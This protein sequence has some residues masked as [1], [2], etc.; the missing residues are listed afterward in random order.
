MFFF[1]QVNESL[2]L[3]N[4]TDITL[5]E[6]FPTE[7]MLHLTPHSESKIHRPL[8]NITQ[9]LSSL[10]ICLN[11]YENRIGVKV[12]S[13]TI[14]NDL[15][16]NSNAKRSRCDSNSEK[17]SPESKKSRTDLPTDLPTEVP[18]MTPPSSCQA[19]VGCG[20]DAS[21]SDEVN[22]ELQ[23]FLEDSIRTITASAKIVAPPVKK[24]KLKKQSRSIDVNSVRPLISEEVVNKIRKGWTI[25]NAAD[26]TIG[27]LYCVFGQDSKLIF[28]YNWID[29]PPPAAAPLPP[30]NTICDTPP[31]TSSSSSASSSSSSI[32]SNKLKHLLMIANLQEQQRTNRLKKTNCFCGH[33]CD[34]TNIFNNKTYIAT[35]VFDNDQANG[36]L[37]MVQNGNAVFR[38]PMLPFRRPTFGV[39]GL[40][41]MSNPRLR[42]R[43]V[44]VQRILPLHP[45]E[46]EKVV[47]VTTEVQPVEKSSVILNKIGDTIDLPLLNEISSTSSQPSSSSISMPPLYTDEDSCCC[48]CFGIASIILYLL[49]SY[50]QLTQI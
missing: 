17:K 43:Q 8:V 12:R 16:V 48:E 21:E 3:K 9:F 18:F 23:D 11:S 15:R 28:E 1:Q 39:E 27:D 40:K 13:E 44:I 50:F 33:V 14:T 4:T 22:D 45:N 7:P 35:K 42:G 10:N 49:I 38:Q 20:G 5:K 41:K 19:A 26:I 34:K 2:K 32:L 47:E 30:E 6:S 46:Q 36:Q 25:L 24:P 29:Q 37:P 31:S